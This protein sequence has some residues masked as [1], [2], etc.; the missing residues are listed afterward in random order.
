MMRI[1]SVLFLVFFAPFALISLSVKAPGIAVAGAVV[2]LIG[3]L[4]V[5]LSSHSVYVAGLGPVPMDEAVARRLTALWK[6]SGPERLSVEFF[7]Y[8]STRPEFR[9]WAHHS[10]RLAIYLSQGFLEQMTD[11]AVRTAFRRIAESRMGDVVERNRREAIQMLLERWKGNDQ[12]FRY[13]FLSFWLYPLER[14]LKIARI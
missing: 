6:Q 3:V 8:R 12:A 14:L 10:R 11:H 2:V 4:G 5:A 9:V 1:V 7:T 13:W